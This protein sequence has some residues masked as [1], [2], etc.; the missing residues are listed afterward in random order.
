MRKYALALV[1]SAALTSTAAP[2]QLV[3][4]VT[5]Q[6]DSRGGKYGLVVVNNPDGTWNRE[7]KITDKELSTLHASGN[8]LPPGVTRD[9]WISGQAH[10]FGKDFDVGDIREKDGGLKI[11]FAE[12]QDLKGQFIESW[13]YLAPGEWTGTPPSISAL[14]AELTAIQS[15]TERRRSSKLVISIVAGVL[16]WQ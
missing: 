2:R 6:M 8:G 12:E 13:L 1:L 11:K 4:N 3:T 7:F 14:P 15:D 5:L 10:V 9:E 16:T